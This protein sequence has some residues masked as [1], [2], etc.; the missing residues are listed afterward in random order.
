MLMDLSL[1]Y[2]YT[3]N[4]TCHF[5]TSVSDLDLVA[6]NVRAFAK[7]ENNNTN[8][9]SIVGTLSASNI[10]D[11]TASP[12]DGSIGKFWSEAY[13]FGNTS[14]RVEF[15]PNSAKYYN[16]RR[17]LSNNTF[18]KIDNEIFSKSGALIGTDYM[19]G[20][21]KSGRDS[22]GSS[23]FDNY[24]TF[25]VIVKENN[26]ANSWKD[27]WRDHPKTEDMVIGL[28]GVFIGWLFSQIYRHIF[29]GKNLE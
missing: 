10:G 23:E 26:L 20:E 3:F 11:I 8:N 25:E 6:K 18:Y 14:Y 29:S 21:L 16:S 27:F 2:D 4:I 12:N 24:I 15:V 5:N 28:V 13:I 17:G 22:D 7:I 1:V 9:I 19:N